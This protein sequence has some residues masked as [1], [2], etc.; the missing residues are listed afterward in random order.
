AWTRERFPMVQ[1]FVRRWSG[2]VRETFDGMGFIG[3]NPFDKENSF[4]ATGDSGMGITHGTI[5]GLLLSDLILGKANPWTEL[6]SPSRHP[7]RAMMKFAGEALRMAGR[8]ADWV[9]GGDVKSVDE[10]EP[11]SGATI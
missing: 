10:I 7:P 4:I 9:T 1:R 11:G 6:Y 3:R 2:E 5:A 8:Y